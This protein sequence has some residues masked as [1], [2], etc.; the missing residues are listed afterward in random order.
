MCGETPPI[1]NNMSPGPFFTWRRLLA[2]RNFQTGVAHDI[3]LIN[4]PHQDY[5]AESPLDRTPDDLARIMQRAKE[6]SAAFLYWLQNDVERD[7]GKG[8]GYP[9]LRMRPDE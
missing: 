3:A 5:A 6:T 9:E 2:A 8:R 7:D 1:P 4:W